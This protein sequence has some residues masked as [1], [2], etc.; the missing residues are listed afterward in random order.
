MTPLPERRTN[1][2]LGY[3][4]D[5]RLLIINADDFGVCHAVNEA[6]VLAATQGV[7][8]STSL[9]V[10]CPWAT[11]AMQLLKDHPELPFGIHLTLISDFAPYRWGPLA[12]KSCVPSLIDQGGHFFRY[13]RRQELLAQA[14]LTEV[15]LEFRAQIEVVLAAHLQ[16]THL[17]WHC[18]ADGGRADIFELTLGL[19]REFGLALR[20]HD[21]TSAENLQQAGLPAN[22]HPVLDSYHLDPVDKSATFARLLR[23]L[24]TGLTEWAVHPSLGNAEA[25][26]L[27]PDTWPVRRADL[28]FLISREAR[29]I[30]DQEGIERLDYRALQRVWSP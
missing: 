11:H 19:A 29:D 20:V 16:P 22:D 10:P 13:E 30:M 1:R 23:E 24:P 25:Q 27:E 7:A 5:A 18:L 12:S 26:A 3:P 15:D 14:E 9:M 21:R 6:I 17:D 8:A 28:D 4:D 2:L